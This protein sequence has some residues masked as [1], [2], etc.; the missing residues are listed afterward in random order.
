L[1]EAHPA[2]NSTPMLAPAIHAQVKEVLAMEMIAL[3]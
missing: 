2:I 1:E 3:F